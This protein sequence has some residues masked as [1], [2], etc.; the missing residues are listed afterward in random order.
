MCFPGFPCHLLLK[1]A[2]ELKSGES[3]TFLGRILTR[4]G[5]AVVITVTKTATEGRSALRV[6][7]NQSRGEY[8]M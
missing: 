4:T 1:T 6:L 5:N 8:P 7:G 2:P 3:M